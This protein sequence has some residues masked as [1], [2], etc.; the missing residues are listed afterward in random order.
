MKRIENIL[1]K[2]S[3]F[4]ILIL[5]LFYIVAFIGQWVEPAIKFGTFAIIFAFSIVISLA[6]TVLRMEKPSFLWRVLIHYAALLIS[7]SV[8]F[9]ISGNIRSEGAGGILSAIIIFT[10]LYAIIFTVTYLIMRA[11]K[12]S[13]KRLDKRAGGKKKEEKKPYKSLYGSNEK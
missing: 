8:I 10:F 3:G 1:L 2:A 12:A 11:V 7:F 5:L 6:N 9:I 4:T 13:D